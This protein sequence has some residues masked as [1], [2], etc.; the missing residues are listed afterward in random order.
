MEAGDIYDRRDTL[1][2]MEDVTD[3]RIRKTAAAGARKK[4]D[5]AIYGAAA[6]GAVEDGKNEAQQGNSYKQILADSM[7][8]RMESGAISGETMHGDKKAAD[9]LRSAALGKRAEAGYSGKDEDFVKLADLDT[10]KRVDESGQEIKNA[11]KVS[12][13]GRETMRRS[14][15]SYQSTDA[16]AR[17]GED[18]KSVWRNI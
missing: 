5:T 8:K 1:E 11:T 13:K 18:V 15:N 7:L 2:S 6:L 3:K 12:E 4:G 9:M 16:G 14:I 10:G 17:V